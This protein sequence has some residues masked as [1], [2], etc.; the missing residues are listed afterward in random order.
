MIWANVASVL[1]RL[2]LPPSSSRSRSGSPGPRSSAPSP[3]RSTSV[4][5]SVEPGGGPAGRS[6]QPAASSATASTGSRARRIIPRVAPRR[7]ARASRAARRRPSRPPTAPARRPRPAPPGPSVGASSSEA[8]PAASEATSG[9]SATRSSTAAASAA[10]TATANAAPASTSATVARSAPAARSTAT[11]PR[12]SRAVIASAWISAYRHTSPIASPTP[13]STAARMPRKPALL[14][15]APRTG[16]GAAP[17]ARRPAATRARSAPAV[18]RIAIAGWSTRIGRPQRRVARVRHPAL[19]LQRPHHA[20]HPQPDL[21]PTG[22]LHRERRARPQAERVGEPEPDLGLA[23]GAQPPPGGQRRR[24]EARVVAGVADQPHRLAEPEGVGARQ[25]VARRGGAHA[26]QPPHR[27]QLRRVEVRAELVAL[28]DRAR[29][30]AQPHEQRG[31]REHQDHHPG[32]DGD[33]QHGGDPAAAGGE[34]EARAEREQ[35][36]PAA[37]AADAGRRGR[38][39]GGSLPAGGARPA[40]RATLRRR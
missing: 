25:L 5:S 20:D 18:R 12:R 2:P 26:G 15:V 35:P 24:L 21:V 19:V 32:A 8:N 14:V 40:T 31:Q 10:G 37:A 9:P 7:S 11:A 16:V 23:G 33:G 13:R 39:R 27:R 1:T 29:V 34:R 4:A 30:V 3:S 38:R 6:P 36:A 22:R 28:A 17:S